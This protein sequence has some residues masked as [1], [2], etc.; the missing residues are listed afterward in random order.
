MP[1]SSVRAG[2]AALLLAAVTDG[3]CASACLNFAGLALSVP[4]AIHVGRS[5]SADSL[6]IDV[7]RATTL[8]A[9]TCWLSRKKYG[10]SACAETT[11][12]WCRRS[13]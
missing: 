10:A 1:F 2:G 3:G 7:G 6:Y 8:P 12:R 11:K 5:A 9:A 13:R 4:G